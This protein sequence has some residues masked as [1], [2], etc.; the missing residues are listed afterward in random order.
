[1]R[2]GIFIILI[3]LF[4]SKLHS[5][6]LIV[7][8]KNPR[9]FAK[10]NNEIVYLTGSH[11]WSNTRT[12]SFDTFSKMLEKYGHNFI[13]HWMMEHTKGNAYSEIGRIELIMP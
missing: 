5:S 9:Y 11:T 3:L 13:R 7:H 10:E 12:G 2:A 4:I 6:P 8:P 1:M